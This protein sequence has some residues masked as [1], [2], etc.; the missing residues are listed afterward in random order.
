MDKHIYTKKK[1]EKEGRK[2]RKFGN[3]C[4][5][6]CC[7]CYLE[8]AKDEDEKL[9]LLLLRQVSYAEVCK[10]GKVHKKVN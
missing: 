1:F 7:S 5:R 6:L 2:A 3:P 4:S 10:V 8:R 9:A